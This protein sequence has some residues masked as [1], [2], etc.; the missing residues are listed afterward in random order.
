MNIF[1]WIRLFIRQWKYT[2]LM[3]LIAAVLTVY[4]TRDI[5]RTYKTN[6]LIYTAVGSGYDVLSDPM[7]KVDRFGTM[8]NFDNLIA[9][10]NS[11]TCL[12]NTALNLLAWRLTTGESYNTRAWNQEEQLLVKSLS[13]D[14]LKKA[15]EFSQEEMADYLLNAYQNNL[16]PQLVKFVE[17]V[18]SNY[19]IDKIRSTLKVKQKMSS[20]ML[21]LIFESNIPVVAKKTLDYLVISFRNTYL[22]IKNAEAQSVVDYYEQE[23]N[24][25]SNRLKLSEERLKNYKSQN[26][27]IDFNEQTKSIANEKEEAQAELYNQQSQK[28]AA[29]RAL[30]K[31]ESR[32]NN[33]QPLYL[34]NKK[35]TPISE[36]LSSLDAKIA[37]LEMIGDTSNT[38]YR[39]L[40]KEYRDLKSKSKEQLKTF[41]S[42][43]GSGMTP[44][45]L[46]NTWLETT[47]ELNRAEA[48]IKVIQNRIKSF[49]KTFED[50]G[51]KGT[52]I[53]QLERD[54]EL[55]EKEYAAVLQSY[56]TAVL[57]LKDT[58]LT[59]ALSIVDPPFVPQNAQPSPR[60]KLVILAALVTFIL[61]GSIL[62]IVTYL[63][64]SIKSI[65]RIKQFTN[66][67]VIAAVPHYNYDT[68]EIDWEELKSNQ[69]L[70]IG[71]S[72]LAYF[73]QHPVSS[74]K[75]KFIGITS[76]HESE[77]KHFVAEMLCDEL[78]RLMFN[79]KCYSPKPG[80]KF[81][82]YNKD[83]LF[84]FLT[85]SSEQTA[86][87]NRV[88]KKLAEK[89]QLSGTE[90][91][92][93]FIFPAFVSSEIPLPLLNDLDIQLKVVDATREWTKS[94]DYLHNLNSAPGD[95]QGMQIILNNMNPWEVEE[96]YGEIPRKR[97]WIRRTTK[98]LFGK[99]IKK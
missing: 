21:E 23:L 72:I 24:K 67:E 85:F 82:Q 15:R 48:K 32:I 34:F 99:L 38:R 59:N 80:K 10:I 78:D 33:Q 87:L 68:N 75:T 70:N 11:R 37:S 13:E 1:S 86:S 93:I 57:K 18:P 19:N 71:N 6:T 45:E 84:N 65:D 43:V 51:P 16:D 96:I 88:R 7:S 4:F 49:E 62:I 14:I 92:V 56:Q 54:A 83:L 63:D 46:M 55:A 76:N 64:N 50:F 94:D 8:L 47:L 52:V 44:P 22:G 77:G 74:T 42:G 73:A 31:I 28:E 26:K 89:L 79:Y 17:S 69:K 9:S 81:V 60:M 53:K 39:S 12:E 27:I 41:N 61:F 25:V 29:L 58:Q 40:K 2:I 90:D 98:K 20:D 30:Q 35:L 95:R 91:F 36:Q 97:S 3:P 66:N 5:E